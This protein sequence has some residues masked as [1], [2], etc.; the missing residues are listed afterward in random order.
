MS[1][2]IEYQDDT[3]TWIEVAAKAA[4]QKKGNQIVVLDVSDVLSITDAFLIVSATND[5]QVLAIAYEV[6]HQIRDAGGPSPTHVEGK[7]DARWVL[8]DYGTFVIHVFLEEARNYYDLE[9][10]WRDV[11]RIFWDEREL[12]LIGAR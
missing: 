11:P 2:T 9:R 3:Q 12:V 5:R 6:E 4:A 8:L 10:L 1:T 7:E